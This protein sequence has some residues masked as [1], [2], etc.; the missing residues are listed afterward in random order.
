M[1]ALFPIFCILLGIETE[2]NARQK[3]NAVVPIETTP[4]GIEI[5]VSVWRPPNAYSPIDVIVL[6]IIVLA[7]PSMRVLVLTSLYYYV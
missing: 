2:V 3:E 6:G 1:N 7:H 5:E 4:L